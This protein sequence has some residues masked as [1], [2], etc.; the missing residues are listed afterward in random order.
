MVIIKWS[1][2]SYFEYCREMTGHQEGDAPILYFNQKTPDKFQNTLR[3][4]VVYLK[5]DKIRQCKK[6]FLVLSYKGVDNDMWTLVNYQKGGKDQKQE[7]CLASCDDR[8]TILKHLKV[9]HDWF[10]GPGGR[11]F[12]PIGCCGYFD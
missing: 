1:L 5:K 9:S 7:G 6:C 4:I 12:C 8:A 2:Q 3:M 10:N 11:T